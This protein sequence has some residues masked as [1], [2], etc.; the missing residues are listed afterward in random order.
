MPLF[1]FDLYDGFSGPDRLGKNC[2]DR[3]VACHEA[4]RRAERLLAE[5]GDWFRSG[6]T[7]QIGVF[8]AAGSSV[9]ILL[10]GCPAPARATLASP[11]ATVSFPIID[12]KLMPGSSARERPP[13]LQV[14]VL[15]PEII[16]RTAPS[17]SPTIDC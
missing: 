2:S 10:F 3:E 12:L 16:A 5:Q 8:D 13:S 17:R 14:E 7:W 9:S 4:R 15:A 1:Y 11:E 6:Q